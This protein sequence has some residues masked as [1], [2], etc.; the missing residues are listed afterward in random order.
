MNGMRAYNLGSR[1]YHDVLRLQ[2]T[3]FRK[4]I[5]R[6]MR[7]IR[8]DKSARLIPNV[9]LLVEH[10][11][12]VYT[13]GRRDTS[14]GIKAGCAAEVVKT[15]RGG[16]VTFHGPGQVTMYPIVNVQVLWKQC[17]ASDKP[18]S[19][20]EW[21]SSVL[22]Q[23]MINVAGEYNIPAHRGR[24]G[25]WSDSWGDVAPRKMGFVGLQLGNWV[26]M[27]GAGLN[28]SNNLL[29]FNDIVM[30]E[31]PNEAATSLVEELRLRGLSGAEPTPHVIAPRL[32][33]HFL[34]SMQQ[35][36]SVV[37][38]ELVDLSIDGSWERSILC[39]LE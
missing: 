38:T 16:G 11:S 8:G 6:Q 19:P 5:D 24:V 13:I 10:S 31:M 1:C 2:E 39:E 12:P 36:E 17:T 3:I 9:V 20:I 4:K 23:A 22:E 15:R 33:H 7:Y 14:N 18:R 35:Q 29:Y 27:H 21:F 37:N 34:L 28:V 32:L 25:V 26:S 30:C